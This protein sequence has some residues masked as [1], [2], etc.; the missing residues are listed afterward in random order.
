MKRKQYMAPFTQQM[1]LEMKTAMMQVN[2]G[3]GFIPI[4]PSHP[5]QGA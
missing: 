3:S 1:R 2:T 4:L 5:G